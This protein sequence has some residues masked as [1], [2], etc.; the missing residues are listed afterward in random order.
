VKGLAVDEAERDD[1]GGYTS[2]RW[3]LLGDE[4][5]SAY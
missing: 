5:Q 2:Y 1:V 4:V 3:E